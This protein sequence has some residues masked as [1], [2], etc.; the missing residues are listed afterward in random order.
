MRFL[1]RN[2]SLLVVGCSTLLATE[3]EGRGMD[4]G[5]P[6]GR[7]IVGKSLTH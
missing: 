4:P 3:N 6:D 2:P 5:Q 7:T 1:A